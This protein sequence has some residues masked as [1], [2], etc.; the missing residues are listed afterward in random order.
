MNINL[1]GKEII[2]DKKY[3]VLGIIVLLAI[4]LLLMFSKNNNKLECVQDKDFGRFKTTEK[5]TASFNNNKLSK[6]N[7]YEKTTFSNDYLELIDV[8]YNIYS[9]QLEALKN[10]GGYNYTLEKGDDFVLY[11]STIDL[12]KIPD[13]TK[14]A[15]GF[16]N[17]WNY[18][19]FKN[20][21]EKNGFN[22]K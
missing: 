19:D 4:I 17:E 12:N 7:I 20:N 6:L 8:N 9:K 16:N 15:V 22:C 5:Y 21:L 11:N 10:A 14:I 13:S 18:E 2:I 1:Q 3:I